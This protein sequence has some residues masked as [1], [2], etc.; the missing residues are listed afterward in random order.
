MSKSSALTAGH[1]ALIEVSLAGGLISP[2]LARARHVLPDVGQ[3]DVVEAA[4][5]KAVIR[6]RLDGA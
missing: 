1:P 3:L 2:Q 5:T 6:E 4:E